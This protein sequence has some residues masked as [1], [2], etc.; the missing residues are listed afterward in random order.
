MPKKE[1]KIVEN[2]EAEVESAIKNEMD[3]IGA[4]DIPEDVKNEKEKEEK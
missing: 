4:G 2:S 1:E 3:I